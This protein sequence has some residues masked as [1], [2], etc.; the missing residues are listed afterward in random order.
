MPNET[1]YP[2]VVVTVDG[3]S[4]DL[5][6]LTS[7]DT[8]ALVNTSQH[9][10]EYG[11]H[12]DGHD[13]PSSQRSS[14][15]SV[16]DHPQQY[17]YQRRTSE[18]S[19]ASS[20]PS[21]DDIPDSLDVDDIFQ[22]LK[23]NNLIKM[24]RVANAHLSSRSNA[25]LEE[26]KRRKEADSQAL[27]N[28]AQSSSYHSSGSNYQYGRREL[29]PV[30]TA[31]ATA[32]SS[33]SSSVLSPTGR[34]RERRRER[35]ISRSID[36]QRYDNTP[37]PARTV[38]P[39][40]EQSQSDILRRAMDDEPNRA[41]D[42]LVGQSAASRRR[43]SYEKGRQQAYQRQPLLRVVG[44]IE[45]EEEEEVQVDSEEE[46]DRMLIEVT[47]GNYVPLRGSAEIWDAVLNDQTIECLCFGCCTQLVTVNDADMIMCVSCHTVSPVEG[48]TGGGGLGLGMKNDDAI[49]ERRRF[50][51]TRRSTT[52]VDLFR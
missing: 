43:S 22:K 39:Q 26:A 41:G 32:S 16:D 10:Y 30:R 14:Q 48:G 12:H 36:R 40:R 20:Y 51:E 3:N 46:E 8:T 37:S 28:T 17:R 11:Q 19:Y 38:A 24:G 34:S 29:S 33:I 9:Y 27:R 15:P 35:A 21:I 7:V 42:G 44:N 5:S 52:G 1:M 13:D 23:A 31:A 49:Y 2:P 25:E 45:E 4:W 47:P 50:E 18:T 6:N